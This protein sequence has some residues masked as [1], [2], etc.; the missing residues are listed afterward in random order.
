M[1]LVDIALCIILAALIAIVPIGC[2]MTRRSG[3]NRH[4]A[5]E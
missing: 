1:T 3:S 5:P 2:V 4:P